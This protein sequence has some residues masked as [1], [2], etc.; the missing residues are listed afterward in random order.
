MKSVAFL[1]TTIKISEKEIKK[2]T[3]CTIVP[4]AIKYLEINLTKNYRQKLC[5]VCERN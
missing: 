5:I 1:Y 3:P 4:K 2:T